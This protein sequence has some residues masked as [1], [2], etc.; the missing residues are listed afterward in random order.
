[1]TQKKYL[2][3]ISLI[4]LLAVTVRIICFVGLIGSDDLSYSRSAYDIATRNFTPDQQVHFHSRL[5]LFLPVAGIF[6][7]FGVSELSSVTFPFFYFVMTFAVLVYTATTYFGK[8]PGII[9]GLLYTFLPL[10]IFHATILLPDLPSAAC[11]ALSGLIVYQ[12]EVGSIS[13]DPRHSQNTTRTRAKTCAY[14]LLGGLTLGWAYLIR[15]TALFF[16]VFVGGY[17]VYL[18][19]SRKTLQWSWFWFWLGFFTIIGAELGYYYWITGDPFSRYLSIKTSVNHPGAMEEFKRLRFPEISLLRYVSFDRFRVLS[20]APDFSFYYFFVLAGATYG[21]LQ[22]RS[23]QVRYFIGW[24]LTVFL[25]LN[26]GSKSLSTYSPFRS[27]PR[28][29][30]TLSFPAIIIMAWYFYEMRH[31]LQKEHPRDMLLFRISLVIPFILGW[32]INFQWFS[33]TTTLFLV[34]A[35][36]LLLL[37]CSETLRTWFRS[38]ISS[39]YI[40][41]VLPIL[42]LYVNLI[43]GVYMTAKAERPR[44]GITCERDIR[45]LLEYPLTH[46]IYTDPRTEEILEYYY[47]YQYDKQIKTFDAGD[48]KSWENAYIVVNWERLFF[49]NR[50]YGFDIPQFLYQSP[51]QWKPYARLGADVNPCVIYEIP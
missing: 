26:F 17:M 5:G 46:T 7:V 47:E 38:Q 8:W 49:L 50:R 35:F 21:V 45:P 37:S 36:L 15:E 28:Y 22:K 2:L 42:L 20:Y 27:V 6:R 32:V 29:F 4:F 10:D 25:L 33:V 31:F 16:G 23:V 24:F 34:F 9:A 48:S 41:V 3:I 14:M 13:A 44:K 19:L 11:I 30:L 18:A 39:K 51:P 1:M 40:A 12:V 43:P